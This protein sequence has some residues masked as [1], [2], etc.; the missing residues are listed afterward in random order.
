MRAL[1][2][3]GFGSPPTLEFGDVDER[4]LESGEIRVAVRAVGVGYFDAVLLSGKYQEKPELPFSPGR[5]LAGRVVEV[6][7]DVDPGL[8]GRTIATIAYGGA[9]CE[10]AIT[11]EAHCLYVPDNVEAVDA[12]CIPTSYATALYALADCG[13]IK[14]AER[15]LVLGAAGTVGT[16]TIDVVRALGGVAVALADTR[17]KLDHCLAEGAAHAIDSSD[18]NWRKALEAAVG[19]VD[20]VMDLVGGALSETAFRCLAPG[21][22]L[23]V[24]GFASGE[25]GRL[26]L[27]LCLLKRSS[28]VGVDLGGF[29]QQEPEA[30]RLLLDRLAALLASGALKPKPTSVYTLDQF[31][32]VIEHL[33]QGRNIGKPVIRI[34]S[35]G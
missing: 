33:L 15:V 1:L 6:A 22:R 35:W 27:N 4:P 17:E 3:T 28:A 23:L 20:L 9:T 13:H 24:V 10:R 5:E 16:A 34:E 2:C 30:S 11:K 18:P 25:I 21:G 12:A 26:P 31:G 29:M 14:P 19:K 8:V 7:P 32:G